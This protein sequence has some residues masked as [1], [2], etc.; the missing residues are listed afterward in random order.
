MV[1]AEQPAASLIKNAPKDIHVAENPYDNDFKTD[2]S[3]TSSSASSLPS[4][5]D[6]GN[7]SNNHTYLANERE[8]S[9]N[10]NDLSVIS[11]ANESNLTMTSNGTNKSAS[12]KEHGLSSPSF[13]TSSQATLTRNYER[14]PNQSKTR[15]SSRENTSSPIEGFVQ[16][17]PSEAIEPRLD[18]Q[19]PGQ[20]ISSQPKLMSPKEDEDSLNSWPIA[21][22]EGKIL[23]KTSSTPSPVNSVAKL[24]EGEQP[25]TI[26]QR[27][28]PLRSSQQRKSSRKKGDGFDYKLEGW[29][30]AN[31]YPERSKAPKSP[32]MDFNNNFAEDLNKPNETVPRVE[33]NIIGPAS[34]QEDDIEQQVQTQLR[35]QQKQKEQEF[36]N[37]RSKFEKLESEKMTNPNK[38]SYNPSS[39][40]DLDSRTSS[41]RSSKQSE[42]QDEPAE[43]VY[44][45]MDDTVKAQRSSTDSRVLPRL[46]LDETTCYQI[47]PGEEIKLNDEFSCY[48]TNFLDKVGFELSDGLLRCSMF[49]HWSSPIGPLQLC[50]DL[51]V[52]ELQKGLTRFLPFDHF[53]QIDS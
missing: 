16:V 40:S 20:P 37:F 19:L 2:D 36:L 35:L 30:K 3:L 50:W 44:S 29:I 46:S 49:S 32:Q 51:R 12:G 31:R 23:P 47:S 17:E 45:E 52:H 22:I 41:N 26:G 25:P 13:S 18:V 27:Q 38:I 43:S 5:P 9:N 48:L 21:S 15:D 34:T 42:I 24:A 10:I 4:D 28:E 33:I 11:E 8:T 7:F 6:L 39:G 1:S 53:W 14:I